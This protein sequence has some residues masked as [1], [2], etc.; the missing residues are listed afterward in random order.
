MNTF[1]P[2]SNPAAFAPF[3][4]DAIT[5]EGTRRSLPSLQG[6]HGVPRAVRGTFRACVIDNGFAEPVA[7]SDAESSLRTF[8]ISVRRGDWIDRMPP[9]TGD[10]VALVRDGQTLRL[11]VSGVGVACGDAW[12]FTAREV[13]S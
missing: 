2:F 9:Q 7:E 12:T 13:P 11:C 6:S 8:G 10:R 1:D 5:V 3:Y 4:R